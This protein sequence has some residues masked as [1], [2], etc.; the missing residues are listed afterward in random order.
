MRPDSRP[1]VMTIHLP[2]LADEAVVEIQN[3]FS[4]ILHLLEAHYGGQIH[5]FYQDRSSANIVE[6]NPRIT[7]DDPPF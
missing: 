3:F 5:R 2:P 6:H 1:V 4:E 7:L